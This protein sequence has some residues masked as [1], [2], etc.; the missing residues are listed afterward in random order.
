MSAQICSLWPRVSSH[1][2]LHRSYVR[3]PNRILFVAASEVPLEEGNIPHRRAHAVRAYESSL[4]LALSGQKGD[5]LDPPSR[6]CLWVRR[7]VYVRDR[8]NTGASRPRQSQGR[9]RSA[10]QSC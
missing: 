1:L 8:R 9:D 6:A 4:L 7:H 10:E 3:G 2:G 5:W